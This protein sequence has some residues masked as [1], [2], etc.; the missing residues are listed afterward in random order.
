M[1]VGELNQLLADMRDT[2]QALSGAGI[3]APQI[4]V[5]SARVFG[6]LHTILDIPTPSQYPTPS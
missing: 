4:G 5:L 3:A 6:T 1:S 2:M